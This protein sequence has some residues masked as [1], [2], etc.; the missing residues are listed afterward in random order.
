MMFSGCSGDSRGSCGFAGSCESDWLG[1]SGR[2]C[3]YCWVV[4][5]VGPVCLVSLGF[6]GPVGP[7]GLVSLLGLVGLLGVVSW[8]F[9]R[10]LI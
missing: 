3:G 1:G 9:S 7:V 4:G 8:V 2:P 10:D 5:L 6:V